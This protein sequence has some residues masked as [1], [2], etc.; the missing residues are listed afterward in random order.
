MHWLP[1]VSVFH[2]QAQSIIH[3]LEKICVCMSKAE[4]SPNFMMVCKFN[5]HSKSSLGQWIPMGMLT[6]LSASCP[7]SL[8][9]SPIQNPPQ[10]SGSLCSLPHQHSTKSDSPPSYHKARQ[11]HSGILTA[12]SG[13][14]NFAL[15]QELAVAWATV[16]MLAL[17][18]V[19]AAKLVP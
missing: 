17:P 15:Q 19:H 11:V 8:C 18:L 12:R 10:E 9:L 5:E 1:W 3:L 13:N 16:E 2:K 4:K 6:R 7:G 14:M